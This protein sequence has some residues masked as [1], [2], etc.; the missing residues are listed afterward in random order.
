MSKRKELKLKLKELVAE[1]VGG[2]ATDIPRNFMS[3]LLQGRFPNVQM[4]GWPIGM[5]SESLTLDEIHTVN[6]AIK[7]GSL[8]LLHH[9]QTIYDI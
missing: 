3:L 1:V 2:S 9:E 6:Q 4:L 7:S 5:K 8:Q